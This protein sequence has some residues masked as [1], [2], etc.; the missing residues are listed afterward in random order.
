MKNNT[1]PRIMITAPAIAALLALAACTSDSERQEPNYKP[2][3]QTVESQAPEADD[4]DLRLPYQLEELPLLDPGWASPPQQAGGIYLAPGETN[5]TLTFTAIDTDGT[6]LWQAERPLSCAGFTL[7]NDGTQDLA[8]LTDLEPDEDS[9]GATTATAYNLETGEQVWGPVE[10]PGPHQG[11]GLVFAAPP[12]EHFGDLGPKVV[13][14]PATGE[15]LYDEDAD[16]NTNVIGEYHGTVLVAEDEQIHAYSSP[17]QDLEWSLSLSDNGWPRDQVYGADST[18]SG[19]LTGALIGVE[20]DNQTLVDLTTGEIIAND[21]RDAAQDPTTGTWIALGEDLAG[22]DETGE[23]I[24]TNPDAEDLQTIE[25]IG[26]V[27]VYLRTSDGRIQV[28]NVV[29]GDVAQA[30]DPEGQGIIATPTYIS[31]VGAAVV[32]YT[33]GYLFTPITETTDEPGAE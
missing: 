10:V 6:I 25:G 22:Y 12:E 31:E 8:V 29:S 4:Q 14:D 33:D 17:A 15:A 16:S 2:A 20:A 30:Y 28:H 24:F 19:F 27:M 26:G 18:N 5:G 13:L 7:T 32:K 3:P 23:Q 11:P 21:L 1:A 9:F